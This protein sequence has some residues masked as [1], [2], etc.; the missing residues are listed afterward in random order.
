ML[1]LLHNSHLYGEFTSLIYLNRDALICFDAQFCVQGKISHF[2]RKVVL[3]IE[4][5]DKGNTFSHLYQ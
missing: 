3:V 5:A 2:D 4:I 1:K